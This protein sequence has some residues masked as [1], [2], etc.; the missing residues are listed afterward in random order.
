MNLEELG[1]DSFL[2]QHFR[3]YDGQGLSPARISSQEKNVYTAYSEF[4]ELTGR[5]SGKFRYNAA[6]K[7]DFPTVGDWVATKV[8]P[9]MKRMII[10]GVLPWRSSFFRTMLDDNRIIGEQAISANVDTVFLVSGLDTDTSTRLVE[11]YMTQVSNSGA[12]YR[13]RA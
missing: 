5:V 8:D 12:G 10:H 11:R 13:H 3:Q 9:E 6:A 7:S 2:H 4:G 1:W